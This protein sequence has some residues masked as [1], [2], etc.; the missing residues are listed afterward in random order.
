MTHKEMNESEHDPYYG[1]YISKIDE[2]LDLLEG[3]VNGQIDM[4]EFYSSI[5]EEKWLY[6]YDEGKWNIK[7]VLQHVIDTERIFMYRCFRISRGDKTSL[8]NFDQDIYIDPSQA[9]FKSPD[10]L[11]KEFNHTRNH[12]INMLES[13]REIDLKQIGKVTGIDMSSRAAA[14]TVIG[15]NVWHMDVTKER[16]L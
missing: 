10:Q 13:L 11:L 9:T 8:A 5:P 6:R 15:H 12:S 7:E 14:F 4:I 1:R 2:N 16:Y 3:F